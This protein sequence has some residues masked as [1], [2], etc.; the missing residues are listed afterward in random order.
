MIELVDTLP[1]VNV[2]P[3]EYK[4]LLGYPRGRVLDGRARE[5][6]DWARTWY[7]KNGR[8]WVYARHAQQFTIS[9]DIHADGNINIDSDSSG[10]ISID[11]ELFACS[12]LQKS[13]LQ[14]Q[15]HG[16]V[17]LAVS[18]GPEL[19]QEAQRLWNEE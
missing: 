6:V 16:V 3:D 8:P 13:L 5:L 7:A 12:F 15:A 14:A 4:R 2:Q 9:A 10:R 18:A 1:D 11:G 19:E 17:L